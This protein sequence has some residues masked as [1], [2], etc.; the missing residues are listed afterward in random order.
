MLIGYGM[1]AVQ[2]VS[3]VGGTWLTADSGAALF[4]GKPGRRSR[5]SRTGALSINIV[6]AEAIVPGIV[7]VLGLNVPPG[8]Q[9]SAAGATATTMRLP[10]GTVCAWLFPQ[11]GGPTPSIA[12]QIDTQVANV[13]VGEVA[14][15]RAMDVGISDGWGVGRDLVYDSRTPAGMH[16]LVIL[17]G[18]ATTPGSSFGSAT[19]PLIP[20]RP[21]ARYIASAWLAMATMQGWVALYFYDSNG[22]M[23][24][25]VDGARHTTPNGG[26]TLAGYVRATVEGVAPGN[27]ATARV[28]FWAVAQ[29]N[30]PALWI[31]RPM[32]EEARSTQ[33]GPSPWQPGASG[34][35]QKYSQVTQAIEARTTINENGLASYFASWTMSLDANGRVA[36]IRSVNNGTTSTIDFLFDRVRFVSPGN[37]RRMEYSDGHFLGYDENNVRRIRLGTWSA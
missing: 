5:I 15:F 24:L 22:Q 7:A 2:S 12:V 36:G 23:V 27:A 10:D 26:S 14:I 34:I 21:G 20:I 3:L 13:E 9:V 29:A 1:P 8:V 4:D 32:L 25:P 30:G 11:A 28:V 37:G 6:L 31:V 16:A 18:G 19:S 33:T 35:D 17:N